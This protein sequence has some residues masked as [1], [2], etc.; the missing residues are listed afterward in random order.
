MDDNELQ[1]I[2]KR[3]KDFDSELYRLVYEI[4]NSLESVYDY[5]QDVRNEILEKKIARTFKA[6]E[7][8]CLFCDDYN[9]M[10][11]LIKNF[12][13]IK[14]INTIKKYCVNFMDNK[15]IH[16][17]N[18]I[19]HLAIYIDPHYF[20]DLP[21][22]IRDDEQIIYLA[23]KNNIKALSYATFR[24]KNDRKLIMN[25]LVEQI[26]CYEFTDNRIK[27]DIDIA[28]L[29]L[30]IDKNNIK[31][32]P[33]NLLEDKNFI[34]YAYSLKCQGI[35]E[36]IQSDLSCDYQIIKHAIINDDNVDMILLQNL[37][38]R[39]DEDLIKLAIEYSSSPNI[40]RYSSQNI[41]KNKIICSLAVI[42]NIEVIKYLPDELKYNHNFMKDVICSINFGLHEEMNDIF[43]KK[44]KH[45][46][47]YKCLDCE[48]NRE[49]NTSLGCELCMNKLKMILNY[50]R[51]DEIIDI[52]KD[53]NS[54][55]LYKNDY[56]NIV[57]FHFI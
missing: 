42:K 10:I 56:D 18:F 30:E 16:H 46:K 26:N 34:L 49:E 38:I 11:I 20:T 55:S 37:D 29:A 8:I 43:R 22:K 24:I 3:L 52:I 50:C 21:I 39:G 40:L 2:A 9:L 13:N 17:H 6:N 57:I 51:N 45:N 32:V 28:K 35:Y 54:Y 36:R 7:F 33:D 12:C 41:K 27:K 53:S 44:D 19:L 25:L 48:K 15:H 1:I 47:G 31:F 5:I 4:S 23:T 14:N